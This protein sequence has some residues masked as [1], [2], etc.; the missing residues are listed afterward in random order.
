MRMPAL[1]SLSTRLPAL[2]QYR[3]LFFHLKVWLPSSVRL[4]LVMS[5]GA[6]NEQAV[7]EHVLVSADDALQCPREAT[8]ATLWDQLK[9]YQV[10]H[11]RGTP[12][13][14]K[15]TLARLLKDYVMRTSPNTQVYAFSFQHPEVIEKK[16]I[17]GSLYYRLL[18][19]HTDRPIDADDW[20]HMRNML[21]IIDEAQMS[22]QYNN[23]WTDFIKPISSDGDEGRRVILFSSYG[24]PA[25]TP[26]MHGGLGSPPLRL[27]A[28]Q[29]VSIRPLSDNNREVSLYFTRLEFDDVVARVCKYSDKDGQP[30]CPSPEL[31]DYVWE[32][33]NGHPA[34]T[35]VVLDALIN[36]KVSI[37]SFYYHLYF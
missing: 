4:I 26:V 8:I 35:R 31:L 1:L 32:F 5:S 24:S 28:N 9:K 33:S 20:L 21:L 36:S 29:R 17:S 37:Y 14:G 12:T 27:S 16:G 22:Y 6:V 23:L 18:N 13:S 19:F 2:L 11:V 7:N 15:S 10:V 34:G 30:F 3:V 25:E